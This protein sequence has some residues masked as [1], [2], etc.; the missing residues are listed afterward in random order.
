MIL[1]SQDVCTCLA[2]LICSPFDAHVHC[3]IPHSIAVLSN[4]VEPFIHCVGY[5][6]YITLLRRFY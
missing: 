6:S 1:T 3:Y 4:V 2:H 5:H